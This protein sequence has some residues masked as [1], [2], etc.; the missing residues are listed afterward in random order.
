MAK[1]V[2]SKVAVC[3]QPR[4]VSRRSLL[5]N[6]LFSRTAGSRLLLKIN[7]SWRVYKFYSLRGFL[8]KPINYAGTYFWLLVIQIK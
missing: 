7:I 6:P 2:F 5:V 4:A 8:K 1:F 3:G